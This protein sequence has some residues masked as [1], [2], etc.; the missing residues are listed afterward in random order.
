MSDWLRKHWSTI[1]NKEKSTTQNLQVYII[2]AY[3]VGVL[4][5]SNGWI[6]I[7]KVTTSREEYQGI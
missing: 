5:I 4:S 7:E 2:L 6:K 3:T 1:P